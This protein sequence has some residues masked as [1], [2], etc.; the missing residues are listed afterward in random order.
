VIDFRY[1]LVS[2]IAVFLA[3]AVGLVIGA[4]ALQSPEIKTLLALSNHEKT[5][6][7]ALEQ[8]NGSRGKQNSADQAFAQ[9]AV[10]RLLPDLLPGRQVVLVTAPGADSVAVSGITAAVQQAGATLTGEVNLLPQFFDT[11]GSTENSLTALAQRLAPAGVT[12]GAA[13]AGSPYGGQ[14][15]AARVLASALVTKSAAGS[16]ATGGLAPVPGGTP[17]Q[18]GTPAAGGTSAAQAGGILS[19]FAQQNFLQLSGTT[20]ITAPEPATLAVVVAPATPPGSAIGPDNQ[21]L[22]AVAQALQA[23]DSGTVLAGSAGG[24]GPGSLIDAVASGSIS[25][26]LVTVDNA[27]LE[28]GQIIVAQALAGLLAG[29]KPAPYGVAPD[30][31]PSPAPEPSVTVSA[32]PAAS[33]GG[34]RRRRR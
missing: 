11:G 13:A 27:D 33:S 7:A 15:A 5:R 25:G 31:A 3:L 30:A 23:A 16:A 12:V 10:G 2:I 19:G 4:A 22:L 1:H 6:I 8:S 34:G 28:T 21:V 32:Q 29:R 26:S 18:G 14:Q 24:S 9:A 17:A 20:G